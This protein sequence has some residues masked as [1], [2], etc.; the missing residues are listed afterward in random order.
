MRHSTELSVQA[1]YTPCDPAAFTF[2]TTADIVERPEVIGQ[3]RAVQSLQLGVEIPGDGY[4][5]FAL[6]PEGVG[7]RFVVES[8][9]ASAAKLRPSPP[10][11]CYINNLSE[12]NKPRSLLLP[13]GTAVR[14]KQD[15]QELIEDISTALPGSF[16]TEEYQSR[17]H[18]LEED[19]RSKPAKS[20]EELQ[21]RARRRDLAMLQTPMGIAFAPVKGAE[22]ISPEEFQKLKPAERERM[23]KEISE[24]QDE[25]QKVMRQIP[26]WERELRTKVRD[27]NQEV[28]SFAIGHVIDDLVATYRAHA[29]VVAYLQEV[30][31]DVIEHAKEFLQIHE[32]QASGR[33]PAGAALAETVL[34]RRYTVNVLVDNSGRKGAPVVYEDHPTY[35]NL[36]GRIEHIAQMG[37][38]VTD[39]NLIKGGA[40][41]RAN[42]G[43][44]V[45]DARKVLMMPFAWDALK[46]A[47]QSRQLRIESLGQAFSMVSTVSLEPEPIPLDV[48]VILIGDAMLYYLLCRFDPE[49]SDLFK[50]SADFDDETQR[51]AENQNRFAALIASLASRYQLHPLDRGAV[52]RVIEYSSRLAGDAQRLSLSVETIAEILR[53][54]SYWA[55]KSGH[56]VVGAAD[57][58]YAIESRDFRS[59]RIRERTR[60]AI[61]RNTV[62]IDTGGAVVGQVNGLSVLQ[63]GR[64]AFG[65]P[66]RITARVRAGKGEVVDIEREVELGGPLHSKGVLILSAFLGASYASRFPLALSASLVFEQSY[67]GV[68]G[69]SAS[70]AELYALL[71][72][73]SETPIRQAYAVTGSVNQ[74]GQV[75]PIGGANEKIEGFFD[76]CAARGLTGEHGVL[77]PASN[78]KHLMLKRPVLE[79]VRDGKFRIHAVETIAQGI[80]VL[81]GIPHGVR[82]TA[83]DYPAGTIG[84]LVQKRLKEMAQKQ[85]EFAR[86]AEGKGPS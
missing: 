40:L 10:D 12:S 7:K 52:A 76:V 28:A 79:A 78:V 45:M 49:F 67:G 42:G 55:G 51:S 5:V 86:L 19:F 27:L 24:L 8:H 41:H 1:L 6:G 47:L 37:T 64:F 39:F 84:A 21:E 68:E 58:D 73:I 26:R 14:L 70:S 30:R 29:P 9:L 63:L 16:E 66:S 81:T 62:Y 61:L 18:A 48:K 50:V 46:R 36:I 3:V 32:A 57:V 22:V 4:N 54:A 65:Q 25:V 38:L 33:A 77:I 17:L 74:M 23:E 69:D 53:E 85:I 60:E 20:F 35:D 15:V 34:S 44:L 82:D 11:L 43:Y 75:Q 13:A 83:G 72:A 71:S 80:E 59:D 56:E 2:E 31:K